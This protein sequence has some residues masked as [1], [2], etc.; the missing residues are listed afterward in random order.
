MQGKNELEK[1]LFLT[2]KTISDKVFI[3]PTETYYGL[4]C[5]A[6][7]DKAIKKIYQIK[8]RT[9]DNPLLLLVNSWEMLDY[10]VKWNNF[11]QQTTVKKLLLEPVTIVL[12]SKGILSSYLNSKN[13]YLGFRLT[14]CS[15]AL[16]L[17]KKVNEPIVGTSAN[18]SNKPPT[19][20]VKCIEKNIISQ[21]DY[22][23]DGGKTPGGKATTV[24]IF[25]P[26]NTI[27]II[28]EGQVSKKKMSQMIGDI[29]E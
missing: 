1:F 7:S 2:R 14:K 26:D 9:Y 20:E 21:V 5:L 6:S 28:R 22:V 29:I 19:Q 24:I 10:Y 23:F 27:N 11:E 3:Y 25:T 15:F 4:G 18:I 12:Q 17:I 16:E 13:H 8:Q